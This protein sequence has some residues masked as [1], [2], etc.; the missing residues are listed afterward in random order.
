MEG[1]VG[2]GGDFPVERGR[3]NSV[4]METDPECHREK[5]KGMALSPRDT[6]MTDTGDG[7]GECLSAG[8]DTLQH[9]PGFCSSSQDTGYQ[10]GSGSL[11][12]TQEASSGGG[13]GS[14]SAL[15]QGRGGI[16]SSGV[17]S[18]GVVNS[19]A[20]NVT[21]ISGHNTSVTGNTST[22]GVVLETQTNTHFKKTAAAE[23]LSNFET[24]SSTEFSVKSGES[25]NARAQYNEG[26]EDNMEEEEE[27]VGEIEEEYRETEEE[28]RRNGVRVVHSNLT[29][30][31]MSLPFR[32]D[33]SSADLDA[34]LASLQAVSSA[35]NLSPPSNLACVTGAPPFHHHPGQGARQTT[36]PVCVSGSALLPPSTTST[37]NLMGHLDIAGQRSSPDSLDSNS[38][39]FV[40][41]MGGAAF[42]SDFQASSDMR[43]T[44]M[45]D[46]QGQRG[47]LMQLQPS[48]MQQHN[49]YSQAMAMQGDF[50]MTPHTSR[51]AAV[52]QGCGFSPSSTFA[53]AQPVDPSFEVAD[54]SAFADSLFDKDPLFLDRMADYLQRGEDTTSEDSGSNKNGTDNKALSV[55]FEF[56][57]QRK[58]A[59]QFE[60]AAEARRFECEERQKGNPDFGLETK[61]KLAL[62]D[63]VLVRAKQYLASVSE[64]EQ[65]L[66]S[67]TSH[68][69]QVKTKDGQIVMKER[70]D[71]L[72]EKEDR[73]ME[74]RNMKEVCMPSMNV[75]AT[76]ATSTST[77]NKG[78]LLGRVAEDLNSGHNNPSSPPLASECAFYFLI[79]V[80]EFAASSINF[81]ICFLSIDENL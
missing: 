76:M 43:Y 47:S 12:T 40:P 45:V 79:L 3:V 65:L 38:R 50:V 26:E 78:T 58:G 11:Q 17:N 35:A 22:E 66:P 36:P 69:G 60:A 5:E 68:Q 16:N 10:T 37:G 57:A 55:H 21:G 81:K 46:V 49:P 13:A 54:A 1:G 7:D 31:F 9:Y 48:A 15:T 18:S 4:S 53:N 6:S 62:D 2:D 59:D 75:P 20:G 8:C 19:S 28:S 30:Q 33:V 77:S 23:V 80:Y 64:R 44:E 74:G 42:D 51:S 39:G 56:E 52:S 73:M 24:R 71:L 29:S 72:K 27:E 25:K 41:M 14:V 34:N 70:Q 61:R 67:Q 63:S 32:S